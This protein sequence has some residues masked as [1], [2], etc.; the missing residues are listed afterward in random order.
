MR[1][2]LAGLLE[3]LQSRIGVS[4]ND[5]LLVLNCVYTGVEMSRGDVCDLQQWVLPFAFGG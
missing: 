1:L 5:W 4:S 2:T 3:S